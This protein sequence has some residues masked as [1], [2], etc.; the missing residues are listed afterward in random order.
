MQHGEQVKL[1]NHVYPTAVTVAAVTALTVANAIDT[2]GYT[3]LRVLLQIGDAAV[4]L[5]AAPK[6]QDCATSGGTYADITSAA[7][8]AAPAATADGYLYAIDI[9]LTR[10]DV[11]RYIKM[12]A[13]KGT[14]ATTGT[15]ASV[16]GI[17]SRPSS[18]AHSGLASPAGLQELVSV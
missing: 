7:L 12:L 9:D 14:D 1:V 2:A 5:S 6:L 13:T 10:G 8:S 11:A 16:I 15:G 4:A 3:H 18:G 17:L